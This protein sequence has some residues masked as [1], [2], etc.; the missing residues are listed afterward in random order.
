MEYLWFTKLDKFDFMAKIEHTQSAEMVPPFIVRCTIRSKNVCH[1][2]DHLRTHEHY[3][4]MLCY[5]D[6]ISLREF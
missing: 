6:E 5:K 2:I 4:Q 1:K 3:F